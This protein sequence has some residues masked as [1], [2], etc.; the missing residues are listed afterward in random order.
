MALSRAWAERWLRRAE[1]LPIS[2]VLGGRA[3]H[4]IPT[5]WK[6]TTCHRLVDANIIETVYEGADP[7]T[8]L[9]VRVVATEYRDYPAVEWVAWF[10]NAGAQATPIISGIQAMD[11]TI[12]GFSP[13]LWHCNGDYCSAEGYAGEE[14]A[15]AAGS[16][17]AYAPNGGRACDG[18]FPYYRIAFQG[19]GVSLAIGW[20]AQWAARFAGQAEGVHVTAGQQIT[21]LRLAPGES[22]RTPRMSLLFWQGDATRGVNLWRRWYLAHILPRPNGQPL[23]PLLALAGTE[24]GE[25]FTAATEENQIRFIERFLQRGIRPDVWWIDAGWYTCL[26]ADG[27]RRWWHTGSW[28][29]D[30]Q[31]F[32]RGL[33]PISDRAAQE[34]AS[35]L[36]WFEPER[37]RPGTRLDREHPEWLLRKSGDDN[38]LLNL[39]NPQARQWLTDHVCKLI[40]DNGIKIYRQ[41]HNFAPLEHWR[42]NEPDD[43]QGMNENLHVQGYLRFWDDLLARNPGLWIDSC[44]S[45]GRRNDLETMRRSVPLHYSD[46]GYGE[47]PVKLAFHR[48]L[49]EWI[50]YF[51]ECTLSYDLSGP[52]RFDWVVDSY[53]FHCGMAAMLFATLDIR[54]DDYDY[55]LAA[56]MIALWRRASG[57]MLFGDYYPHTPAHRSAQGWVA[58]QFDAPE[59]GRGLVQAIR[60]PAAPQESLTVHLQGL[61]PHATYLFENPETGET[62][63]IAGAD[64]A[65]DG[66]TVTLTPRSGACWF[67]QKRG[68][69]ATR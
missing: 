6:P 45:G 26:N 43:R 68:E 54:R 62:K 69:P 65:R 38:A 4:G 37:V 15:L 32:P 50:P 8:G 48:T 49:F 19:W 41:D 64:L 18:A 17:L 60:L 5:A 36:V 53:S 22:I 57:L 1:D 12:A 14:T 7:A 3:I 46:Y 44:A 52:A 59:T 25:E 40:A 51:K 30:P 21:H 20:P 63:A 67:Y 61:C 35:L 56:R 24:E 9:N 29:P 11:A 55:A 58:W 16:E 47:H 39:G 42:A 2:F 13:V 66:F 10:S 31:R 34:D 28:E 33:K 23:Q 27:E